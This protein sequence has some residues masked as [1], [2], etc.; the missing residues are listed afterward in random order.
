MNQTKLLLE[1]AR[2]DYSQALNVL[3]MV[4]VGMLPATI[5]DV[6]YAYMVA[7]DWCEWVKNPNSSKKN[8]LFGKQ[9]DFTPMLSMFQRYADDLGELLAISES[10]VSDVFETLNPN[11]IQ[12]WHS[13]NNTLKEE[14]KMFH[15]SLRVTAKLFEEKYG[16]DVFSKLLDEKQVPPMS[17]LNKRNVS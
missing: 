2:G 11:L 9:S 14:A 17:E 16:E 7:K 15:R 6:M 1:S 12:L 3:M 8:P 4:S 5:E 10:E 13:K